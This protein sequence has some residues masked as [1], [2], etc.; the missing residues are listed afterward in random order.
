VLQEVITTLGTI[1]GSYISLNDVVNLQHPCSADDL[2]SFFM[3]LE[4]FGY[5]KTIDFE[6]KPNKIDGFNIERAQMPT[7]QDMRSDSYIGLLKTFSELKE[8]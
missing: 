8:L 3:M 5:H 2:K 7:L 6:Q 1:R 4:V